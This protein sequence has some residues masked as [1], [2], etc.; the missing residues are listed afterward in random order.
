MHNLFK[1]KDYNAIT[2][3]AN[4][5]AVKQSFFSHDMKYFY[6]L[7]KNS[8]LCVWKWVNDYVSESYKNLQKYQKNKSGKKLKV[9]DNTAKNVE[10]EEEK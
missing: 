8:V 5:E 10:N 6:T 2:F 4:K 3:S 9:D 7:D 1:I